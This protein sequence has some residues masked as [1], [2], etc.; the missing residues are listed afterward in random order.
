M[1]KR[2]ETPQPIVT[3]TYADEGSANYH[4]PDT[5]MTVQAPATPQGYQ[6]AV[7][8]LKKFR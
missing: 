3:D 2:D 1:S 8:D 5:G 4:D 7:E 6:Q